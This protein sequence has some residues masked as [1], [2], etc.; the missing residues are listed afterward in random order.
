M[1]AHEKFILITGASS[2]IGTGFAKAFARKGHSLILVARRLDRLQFLSNELKTLG[3]G[4]IRILDMDLNAPEAPK[5]IWNLCH[6]QQ[7]RV[8]GLINNAGLGWQKDLLLLSEEQVNQMLMVNLVSLTHLCRLFSADMTVR[9][10]G[11]ILNIASTAG[12][13]PVPHFSVYAATKSYVV[14]LSEG[15]YEELKRSNVLVSCLCP[16][17]VH[18][19]FQEKAQMPKRIFAA[20]QSVEEVVVAG[21]KLL[22]RKRAL[23]WTS[24]FQRVFSFGSELT[25]RALRRWLA[26]RLLECTERLEPTDI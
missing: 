4:S 3:A 12:F 11:F 9:R 1:K 5:K 23:G 26:A 17:P 25:P 15:L 7:W 18:T 24:L 22:A 6:E 10:S 16:G 8:E 19:E 14:S 2:G 13:Q 21:M 20:A